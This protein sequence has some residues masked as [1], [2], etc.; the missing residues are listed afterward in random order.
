MKY[1]FLGLL[2]LLIA[3]NTD[4]QKTQTKTQVTIDN[5]YQSFW[6]KNLDS[7]N[8]S[9]VINKHITAAQKK[10][11]AESSANIA[12]DEK[13]QKEF[14]NNVK[15]D[16]SLEHQGRVADILSSYLLQNNKL[17]AT[18]AYSDY[19]SIVFENALKENNLPLSLANLPLALTALNNKAIDKT[20]AGGIWLIMYANARRQGLRVDSYVDERRDI[21][22]STQAAVKELKSYYEL[23]N[24]WELALAAY[25]CG[26]TNVNKAIRRNGNNLDYDSIY[27]SLPDFGRDV[28]P[29]LTAACV[30]DQFSEELGVVKPKIDFSQALDTI[31]VSQRLHFV[32]IQDLMHI[33]LEELRY[34]N[35]KYKY[36]IVP[37]V[38]EIFHIYLP[39]GNLAKFNE[40]EDSIYH[41]KDTILFDLKK[42]VVLPPAAKGRHY[43]R[44]EPE[45]PPD[46]STLVYYTIKSGDN[47]G[48]IASWYGVKVR[49]IEDW[50]NIYDPRRL[51]LGKKLKIYVPENKANYYKGVDA[52]S[53]EQKQK[54]VGKNV[55][56]SSAASHAPKKEEPL[57]KDFFWYTVKSGES[58]YTIAKKYPGV[59][60]DDI[61]RWNNI[62]NAR[63][64][65]VGQKLK[66]KKVK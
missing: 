63:N 58:P 29:A 47:L 55:S 54:R 60:S 64:I 56:T 66:I 36:D 34:L 8:Q 30:L 50:N 24:N 27:S 4:A 62:T 9:W 5:Y 20:G 46:N 40:L 33:P 38:N 49:Q 65:K 19:L 52:M 32:Q 37:A 31:E 43:A 53:F 25:T 6:I 16:I 17:G 39:A 18:L 15:M 44:Y 42:P 28:V 11:I 57:G 7:L 12:F 3:V 14:I 21:Y 61:L 10:L 45:L 59:S 23:Y 35:P 22:L 1:I 48:Y 13:S 2:F 41:Y 51:K 26:P